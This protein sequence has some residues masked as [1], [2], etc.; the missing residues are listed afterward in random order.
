MD[1]DLFARV[2]EFGVFYGSA[3]IL[4]AWR[5]SSFNL[6]S[7][8]STASKLAEMARFHH[9]LARE[10]PDRIG[11]ADVVAGDLRLVRQGLGRM[12]IR[13][14]AVLRRRPDLLR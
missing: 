2:C 3:D 4:A 11:A 12:R 1:V 8:T 5:N 13:A 14:E 7:R 6:C 9:R 10:F